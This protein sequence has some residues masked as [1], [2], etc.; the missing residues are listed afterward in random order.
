VV[1]SLGSA[2]VRGGLVEAIKHG[3]VADAEYLAW[4]DDH[5]PELLARD[6][7]VLAQLASRSVE[8]KSAIVATDE[9]ENGRRAILNAGHT[10]GHAL[11]W[12]SGYRLPH[13]DAVALG[14]VIEARIAALLDLAPESLV[15]GLVER[16]TRIGAPLALP[17]ADQ[18][19]RLL[20]AMGRDKKAREGSLR[21][22]LPRQPGALIA[23]AEWT[24]AVPRSIVRQAL[25]RHR[26][27]SR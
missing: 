9:R 5:C 24:T 14:L 11:E 12:V 22:A 1:R 6:P 18:D 8:I 17:A 3:L 26:N 25:G 21:L 16:F 19:D 7:D 20:E 10:V 23:A 27:A 13:G 4:I 2:H 15:F